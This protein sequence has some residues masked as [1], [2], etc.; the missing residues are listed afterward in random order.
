MHACAPCRSSDATR[1]RGLRRHAEGEDAALGEAAVRH[2]GASDRLAVPLHAGHEHRRRGGAWGLDP[3]QFPAGHR[4]R[5]A[6]DLRAAEDE[7]VAAGHQRVDAEG[8]E[9][10]P[11]RHLAVVL[12]AAPAVEGVELVHDSP[13]VPLRQGAAA[14]GGRDPQHVVHGLVAVPVAAE[15]SLQGRGL[16]HLVDDAAVCANIE[17]QLRA[18]GVLQHGLDLLA[19]ALLAAEEVREAGHVVG[20]VEAVLRGGRLRETAAPA[21]RLVPVMASSLVVPSSLDGPRAEVLAGVVKHLGELPASLAEH[22]RVGAVAHGL[23]GQGDAGVRQLVV[24]RQG[25][26]LGPDVVGLDAVAGHIA[27]LNILLEDAPPQVHAL[28]PLVRRVQGVVQD[29]LVRLRGVESR[30]E[31]LPVLHDGVRQ[32][33]VAHGADHGRTLS[34]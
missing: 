8:G 7:L 5:R 26:R 2:G 4:D 24:Q 21:H 23:G 29:G 30:E 19:E 27:T 25:R 31:A 14:G 16:T 3:E 34:G 11:R 13:Q 32:A 10:V 33:A 18:L 15:G 20:N 1:G 22:L 28:G 9:N 12:V 17:V 6:G